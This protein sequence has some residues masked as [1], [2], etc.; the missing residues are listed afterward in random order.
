MYVYLKG[1]SKYVVELWI[2]RHVP[3]KTLNGLIYEYIYLVLMRLIL[4]LELG[5]GSD[6]P[7]RHQE[8]SCSI[9]ENVT[10]GQHN[11]FADGLPKIVEKQAIVVRSIYKLFIEGKTAPGIAKH[12]T[13]NN[14]PTPAGKEV[15]QLSTVKSIR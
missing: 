10:G 6:T 2:W 8:E 3:C 12:L 11:R 15:G 7:R 13:T 5:Q 1:V 14:I 9:S 4:L